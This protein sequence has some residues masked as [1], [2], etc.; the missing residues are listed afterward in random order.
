MAICHHCKKDMLIAK[1]CKEVPIVING[2]S[3]K[4]IKVGDPHDFNEGTK[5]PCG[6]CGAQYGHFHHP[7]CD[8]ERCPVCHGQLISCGCLDE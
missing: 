5:H 6:D 1:G 7:G 4:P 8:Q 2:V 3:H